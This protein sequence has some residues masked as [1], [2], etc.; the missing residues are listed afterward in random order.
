MISAIYARFSSDL[1]SDRSITDQIELCKQFAARN[2]HTIGPIYSDHA[3]SGASIIGRDGLLKM[4]EDAKA[5]RFGALIVEA[6]DRVSRDQEDLAA[7]YKRLTFAGIKIIAVHEGVA[8]QVQVGIRGLISSIY[9][10]DLAHKVRRGMAGVV[11]DG[12]H[13]G[14]R[15][16][17]YRPIPGRPGELE[18]VEGE[19]EIVRRIFR[20]YAGGAA[21]REIAFRLNAEGIAPPRGAYWA[22][23]TINGNH[24]RLC[25]M[26]QNELY[27]GRLV[28]NRV[29]MVKDPDTGKRI[30]RPR[31]EAE[32]QR[33]DAPHLRIVD[34]LMFQRAQARK[35]ELR[36]APHAIK[37]PAKRL[38]SGLL[39][40]GVCGA[41]M[42]IKDRDHGR[43][44]IVCTSMKE[45]GNCWNR[46][47]YYLDRIESAVL[48]EFRSRLGDSTVM[49][50]FFDDFNDA[51]AREYRSRS[52]NRLALEAKA[53]KAEADLERT[54]GL[55]AR[56]ILSEMEAVKL[57][58]ELREAL[59]L[60]LDELNST[61]A[62]PVTIQCH[63]AAA[64][65]F[66]HALTSLSASCLQEASSGL[67]EAMH[68]VR[69][70]VDSVVVSKIEGRD[71]YALDLNGALTAL[72]GSKAISS[73]G[74][75][76]AEEGL[77]PPTPGL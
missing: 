70:M 66:R 37:R 4:L 69:G 15:A 61:A 43:I 58:P 26:V 3:K 59:R 33:A 71:A 29:A 19:A 64:R 35:Q 14:G 24:K 48:A 62:P 55:A 52:G 38:L 39:K 22:A 57:L 18:I 54:I 74:S 76:V 72:T 60:A 50:S 40:C 5:S 67:N 28:W 75:V 46:T 6:L 77:E 17:G 11:R 53:A 51:Q 9:L 1:Q 25:G 13:A 41:G 56:G 2:G 10:T 45:G 68:L 34:D 31:P 7:I 42:S 63:P 47:N 36:H 12:R 65:A 8:D 21:P 23:N 32:W 16:Y 30:S 20:E 27:A 49:Q 44:R 73:G